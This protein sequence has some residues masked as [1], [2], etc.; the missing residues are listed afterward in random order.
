MIELT[1]NTVELRP[2][3][4]YPAIHRPPKCGIFGVGGTIFMLIRLLL[5]ER[6]F[7]HASQE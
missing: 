5:C 3:L 7:T 2:T 6:N 4:L 1:A